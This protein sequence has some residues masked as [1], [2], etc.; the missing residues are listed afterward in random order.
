MKGAGYRVTRQP[1]EFHAFAE[2]G[3]SELAADV[4]RPGDV[5]RGHRLLGHLAVGA[6][7]RDR[8][9]HA[10]RPRPGSGQH[11]H[12]RLRGGATGRTSPRATSRSSSVVSAPSRSRASYAAAHGASGILFFNQGDVDNAGPD[13]HPGRDPQQRLHRRDPCTQPDLRARRAA[14]RDRRPGDEAVRKRDPR[15]VDHRE[16]DRRVQRRRSRQRRDGGRPPRLRQRGAW[17]QRQ[18]LRLQRAARG[19]RA[20]GQGQATST[21]CGSRGGRPRRPASSGRRSTW[22]SCPTSRSP[23]TRCT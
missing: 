16:P 19:R 20:A 21:S 5:R 17:H 22:A 10:C 8:S 2:V 6:R 4:T 1:F 14:R 15:V 18:R 13:G 12:Q 9:R 11:L 3:D 23:S 7:R